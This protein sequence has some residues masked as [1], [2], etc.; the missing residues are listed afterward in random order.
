MGG[1]AAAFAIHLIRR[2]ISANKLGI[3]SLPFSFLSSDFHSLSQ[4]DGTFSPKPRIDFS[5]VHEVDDAVFLFRQM[6]RMRPK[7]SVVQF[8]KL[9]SIIVKMKQYHVALNLFEEMRQSGAPVN[10]YTLNIVINCYCLLNRVDFGFVIL[11]NFF[12]RGYEPDVTTF[13][14][15]IKG[16]FLDDK[17]MEAEKLFKKLL[18]LKLCEPNEVTILTVINGLCKAGHTLAAY[19]LLGLFEKTSFK[20]DVYS[21]NTVID[22]LCKDRMVDEALQLLAKMIDKGI[23]PDIVTYSSVVQGL[24][25]FGRWK[26]VKDLINEMVDYKISLDVITFNILVDSFCKDGK[27][28]VE[29]AWRLFLEV[30]RKGLDYDVV[31]YNTMLQGLF[32]AGR[33]ADG[34]KLFKDMQGEQLVPDLVTYNILLNGLCMNKQITEAF[35]FL[36]IM[37][38]KGVNPDLTTY[39]ILIHGLCKD[40]KLEI[41]RNLFN[42]LPSKGLQPDVHIYTTIIGSLCQEEFVEVAKCLLIE[43]EKSGCAPN[44]VTYNVLIKGLLERNELSDA[45]TFLDEM[46]RRGLSLNSKQ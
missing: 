20:P 23:A 14:T 46:C 10:E 12:K 39:G 18:M 13:N 21:Y 33:C 8:T 44:T 29:E 19:D 37:E 34:L 6:L 32:H 9:L 43:M 16:L 40:G 2:G 7:P 5:C 42:G 22:R 25:N 15:L 30:P 31:T 38:E 36:H 45:K 28:K 24:C 4:A 17:V 35:S 41:A 27:G 3:S 1:K 26:D 11:G